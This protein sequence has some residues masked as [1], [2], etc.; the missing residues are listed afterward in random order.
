MAHLTQCDAC[1]TTAEVKDNIR[2]HAS[3]G[4]LPKGWCRVSFDYWAQMDPEEAALSYAVT[5]DGTELQ[6]PR[7]T[8]HHRILDLCDTCFTTVNEALN[9][10]LAERLR[11]TH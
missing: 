4:G 9:R 3:G 1:K 7:E 6:G 5:E 11:T 10:A 2:I 8:I